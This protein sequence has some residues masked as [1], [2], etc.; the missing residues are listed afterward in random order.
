M[1]A[2]IVAVGLVGVAEMNRSD[3]ILHMARQSYGKA[4]HLT[5]A[6]LRDP[7]EAVKDT[8]MLSVLVLGLFEMIGG[9]RAR[10]IEAWQKHINGAAA[11]ARSEYHTRTTVVPV[12]TLPES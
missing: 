9:S 4:L 8:T 1:L 10:G 11:L 2:G 3:A 7:A 5:N 6:A 12:W